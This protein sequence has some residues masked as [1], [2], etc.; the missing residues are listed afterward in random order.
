MLKFNT[1]YHYNINS[2]VCK[3]EGLLIL[4]RRNKF[5]AA[6]IAFSMATA[7]TAS[8]IITKAES[9]YTSIDT[10]VN[11][12][13]S[14]GSFYYYNLAYG[15]ILKLADGYEKDMLLSKL[16]IASVRV[17]TKDITDIVEM[18]EVM[19]KEKSGRMYDA[20]QIKIKDSKIKEI[21]KEYLY[22][23]LY[24]WGTNTVWTED[25]KAAI[26]A[27]LKVW[28]DKTEEAALLAEKAISE[29][30]VEI[31]KEYIT[32]LLNE[33]KEALGIGISTLDSK[34]FDETKNVV[35]TGDGKSVNVDL[36]ADTTARTVTLKGQFNNINVN[37][38]L[39]TV[40]L[41]D[42]NVNQIFLGDV[43]DHTLDLRGKTKAKRLIVDDKNDNAHVILRG[44][45]TVE[46]GEIRS[47][48]KIE[49]N[50]DSDVPKPFG[51]LAI[52]PASRKPVELAGDFKGSSLEVRKPADLK[53]SGKVG[54][55]EIGKDAKDTDLTIE[56]GGSIAERKGEDPEKF[57]D[58]NI[59]VTPPTTDPGTP[60][61]PPGPSKPAAP[62]LTKEDV[63]NTVSG[64]DNT[65]EY[66]LDSKGWKPYGDGT[67]FSAEDLTGDHILLVRVAKTNSKPAGYETRLEFKANLYTLKISYKVIGGDSGPFIEEKD[68]TNMTISQLYEA[69]KGKLDYFYELMDKTYPGAEASLDS[70]LNKLQT[71][72]LAD[73]RSVLQYI[74]DVLKVKNP[75]GALTEA[76]DAYMKNH[77]ISVL[78]DYLEGKEFGGL[79]TAILEAVG[80]DV[81]IPVLAG[82]LDLTLT[83]EGKTYAEGQAVNLAE[84]AAALGVKDITKVGDIKLSELRK[85]TVNAS[86][87]YGTADSKKTYT[88]S[89]TDKET[90][91]I[92]T[93]SKVYEF[94]IITK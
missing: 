66:N 76:L 3:E 36:S 75:S 81:T 77:D 61:P 58:K 21:D 20:L 78:A 39:A 93:L 29:V 89:K 67:A 17:W 23:E 13:I 71:V 14:E 2:N 59:I 92:T 65:M 74:I 18:F 79:Y 68:L 69:Y 94:K 12:T 62:K 87:S 80:E 86:V 82:D 50:T 42:V 85:K 1:I 83:V 45:A 10:L 41:E 56:K 27:V 28:T 51:K 52:N 91:K 54:T 46:D 60:T 44:K 25:Y 15:K 16:S 70:V 11:T 55:L 49:A 30:T 8:P 90:L 32:E 22:S 19:A 4:K 35:Y 48:A 37:A 84:V 72:K 53:V 43:A 40:I 26:S 5:I 38:P 73:N 6:L 64:M 88:I 31:N 24:S 9:D 34:Y 63:D 47:G 33:A 57:E 7:I